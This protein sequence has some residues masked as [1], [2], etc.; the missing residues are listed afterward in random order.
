MKPTLIVC[1]HGPGISDAVAHKFG[2]QGFNV[3]LVARNA[4]RLTSAAAQLTESGYEAKAFPCDLGNP[5]AVRAT[6]REIRAALGPIRAI[7]YNAYAPVAGDVLSAPVEELRAGFDVSVTGLI[8]AVQESLADLEAEKG[9]VLVTGGGFAFYDAKVDE[10][11]VGFNA[12]GLAISKAA[13]HKTVG[14]LAKR[15]EA[16]G[17]YVG[18]VV[19]LGMVKGTAFDSGNA[20][21]EASA[22]ADK[23]WELY[24]K[25]AEASVAFR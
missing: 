23:F 3:A 21:L 7:H 1:G 5:E 2:S 14:L 17:V 12:M 4:A 13:Q 6:V 24:T 10:M 19:V 8:V 22:I 15:L 25:R 11:A 9:A 18:E 20:T 16:K